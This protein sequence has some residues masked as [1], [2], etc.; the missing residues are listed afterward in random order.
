MKQEINPVSIIQQSVFSWTNVDENTVNL[1]FTPNKYLRKIYIGIPIS[2]L[3]HPTRKKYRIYKNDSI[4]IGT[5]ENGDCGIESQYD[6]I[7]SVLSPISINNSF[8]SIVEL[9]SDILSINTSPEAL[10]EYLNTIE[11]VEQRREI[12]HIK[13][14]ILQ[15]KAKRDIEK[16]AMQELLDD[17][18]IFHEA[19]KRPP[20]PKDVVDTVWNRDEGKCVYCGSSENLHL[21]HIIPFSKGGDTSVENLQL[22]C[23]KCNL[24]KSNK[25]G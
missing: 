21:D 12:N 8:M 1:H 13:K 11:E 3:K 16:I 5:K 17:G 22:L 23:Q 25:I 9:E 19:N 2:A 6:G 24:E 7:A 20:I 18:E 10:N 14:R 4:A 15:N